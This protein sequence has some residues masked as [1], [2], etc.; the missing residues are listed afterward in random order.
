MYLTRTGRGAVI[1]S[2]IVF[3]AYLA[4]GCGTTRESSTDE[5]EEQV[6][7]GYG[8]QPRQ[9]VTGAIGSA[10][11]DLEARPITRVE[12]LLEGV[13][14]VRVLRAPGGGFYVQIRGVNSFYGN[15]DPLYVIDGMPV[16]VDPGQGIGWLNPYDIR[17]IHVLKDGAS[18]AIYGS[19]GANG[20]VIIKT[21]RE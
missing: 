2:I 19:R 14:G 16:E 20:V 10:D 1:T 6:S 12:E 5:N 21:R 11:V 13:S 8:S 4:A 15:T 3:V 17:S 7:V 9:S 18:A